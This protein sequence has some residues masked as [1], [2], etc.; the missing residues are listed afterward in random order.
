M[1]NHKKNI[2]KSTL[3]NYFHLPINEA[4]K[5]LGV[6]VTMLKKTC[7]KYGISRWPYRRIK[8]I[9]KKISVLRTYLTEPPS[10]QRSSG[11]PSHPQ[12]QQQQQRH[13]SEGS[14]SPA[15]EPPISPTPPSFPVSINGLTAPAMPISMPMA[16]APSAGSAGKG[17][18]NSSNNNNNNNNNNSNNNNPIQDEIN[19]CL[20]KRKNII[21][22]PESLV[23]IDVDLE[24]SQFVLQSQHVF[25]TN[26]PQ[27]V[28]TS[29]G[30]PATAAAQ[31]NAAAL[32]AITALPCGSPSQAQQQHP[33]LLLPPLQAQK[34]P[35][36]ESPPLVLSS[37][38]FLTSSLPSST[39]PLPSFSLSP[40]AG[41]KDICLP[42]LRRLAGEQPFGTVSD[43]YCIPAL[44]QQQIQTQ[45][46]QPFVS[47]T[48][49][50]PQRGQSKGN[51]KVVVVLTGS[52]TPQ[53]SAVPPQMKKPVK[54]LLPRLP[55]MDQMT[56][57]TTS[58]Q[59]V[60]QTTLSLPCFRQQ[61]QQQQHKSVAH[62]KS[63]SS[64]SSSSLSTF[65]DALQMAAAEEEKEEEE[66]N[67][68]E[69]DDNNEEVILCEGTNNNSS[70]FK[71][72]Q[73]SKGGDSLSSNNHF[74]IAA[75][76][77]RLSPL[78]KASESTHG[79][80]LPPCSSFDKLPE[81][82]TINFQDTF[83]ILQ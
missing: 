5:Q 51:E 67:D 65:F 6:C 68:D 41:N 8:C 7:R 11:V 47:S 76:P 20:I 48:V 29:P 58:Q 44:E 55:L 26:Q 52:R 83:G 42:L 81:S 43:L 73:A 39:S 72:V 23:D 21:L 77:L 75:P 10:T 62:S 34:Q 63:S 71:T 50:L 40:V 2:T 57:C 69:E 31:A 78:Q 14:S 28:N 80:L 36:E 12:Q 3:S 60:S 30:A 61:K 45:P 19:I 46:Q 53:T 35:T 70:N 66:E 33:S 59:S 82:L 37:D 15:S 1:V 74:D 13:P 27:Q 4:S 24:S 79:L 38:S 32:P 49:P 16:C 18:N 17:N 56:S 9:D 25:T 54:T 64:S 22:H